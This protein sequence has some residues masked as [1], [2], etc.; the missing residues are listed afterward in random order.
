MQFSGGGTRFKFGVAKVYALALYVDTRAAASALKPY[1]G[2]KASKL[3][4]DESFYGKIV[5][6]RHVIVP[7]PP[8]R[9]VAVD[10]PPP[11]PP[12]RRSQVPK[13]HAAHLS[14]DGGRRCDCERAA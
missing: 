11:S 2:V 8:A 5:N 12:S 1:A 14:P 4:K 7:R 13:V 6:G 10:P 9:A 3:Q